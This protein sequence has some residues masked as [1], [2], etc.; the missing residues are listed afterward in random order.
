MFL[1][2][3]F[4]QPQLYEPQSAWLR[5]GPF[6]LWLVQALRPRR[7]VELGTHH[8]Y[9]YFCFCQ[10]VAEA[11]LLTDCYAVDTWLGDEH[12]G[13]YG[14]EIYD[15]VVE[16]NAPY[17]GFSKLLR[18]TFAE[19]LADIEDGS[20]D[21]LHVDGRHFYEDVKEDF[22]SW[23]P[24]LSPRAVVLFHDT[25]VKQKG[26]GV[27]RYW[28]EIAPSRPSINLPYQHGLGVLF[29]GS[30]IA[31]GLK[32]FVA[33]IDDPTGV[34]GI[35]N[36][37]QT[38]GDGFAASQEL[39]A[40]Q[41]KLSAE[42]DGAWNL[43]AQLET[44]RSTHAAELMAAQN[45]NE[46]LRRMVTKFLRSPLVPLRESIQ[47]HCA[48]KLSK[49]LEKAR[50]ATSQKYARSAAKRD[51]KR[52]MT[53]AAPISSMVTAAAAPMVGSDEQ[54]GTPTVLLP[55]A[56]PLIHARP[57]MR[58]AV[59]LHVYYLDQA[60][61]FRDALRAIPVPFSLFVSTDTNAKAEVL[62]K[63]FAKGPAK[64]TEVRV[65]P[66]RGRAIAPKLVGF[67]DI[68]DS[69]ELILFLHTKA[70]LHNSALHGWRDYLIRAL[71]GSRQ[72]VQSIL[73]AFSIA[74]ELGIIAPPN[75]PAVREW[76][77]WTVCYD[78]ARTLARRMGVTLSADSPVAFPAGSMFWAR[79]AAIRPLLDSDIRLEDF[80]E[81][82]G[83]TDGTFAHAVER[84]FF[85]AC[86]VAGL[87]W[88][89][90]GAPDQLAYTDRPL[91][92]EK[93]LDLE[94]ALS[95]QMPAL[96]L[97]GT[98]PHVKS[99]ANPKARLA[100][101][102]EEF[103][104]CCSWDLR[105]FL[106]SDDR[107][108]F[109]MPGDAPKLSIILVLYNQ[110]ELTFHCLQSLQ[111]DAGLPVEIIILDNGSTDYTAALLERLD[112]VTILR[113]TENLH[114]LRGVNRAAHEAHGKHLLLLNNDARVL[115]MAIPT[116]IARLEE[117]EGIGAVGGPIVLLD[118]TLQ[119]AGSIIFNNAACLGYGRGRDP[120][121][122][123]FRFRRDVDYCSGA[124]LMMRRA[125]WEEL[126]GFDES[127]APAYYEET[128]LCMRIWETGRRVV[129]D[130]DVKIVHFEFGSSKTSDAAIELQKRNSDIFRFKHAK[131][132]SSRHL[133]V[134]APPVRARQRR[135]SAPRL[136]VVDDRVPMPNLGSGYP[137]A[138]QML[139]E[140]SAAGWSATLYSTAVPYFSCEKAYKAIPATTELTYG[141]PNVSLANFLRD[142]LGCFDTILISRPHNMVRFRKA[143][144]QVPGWERVPILYDAEA[145]FAERDFALSQ[146]GSGKV[147]DYRQ[148]L[149]DELALAK[150]VRTVFSVSGTEAAT[151]RA[152]GY[153]DVRIL[154]HALS[155][156]PVGDGPEGR[157][158]ML[159]VGALDDDHSP[160]VDSLDWFVRTVMPRIDAA[161]G[162][163]WWLDVAGR[164]GA[165]TL[166]TLESNR[167]RIHGKID[168]LDP[169]YARSRIFIAPT[170]YAA[171]IPMKVHE[172]ASVGLPTVATDLLAR[173]LSWTHGQE[174]MCATGPDD[175]AACCV[176]LHR[177]D[178]LWS[179]LRAGGLA[180][181]RRD[182][183][184][185]AFR[186][187]LRG[188]LRDSL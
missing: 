98:R 67:A 177:D 68:Y 88:L 3:T 86:E 45:E 123:E 161:I 2:Y 138:A 174:L 102:K 148:A 8:G 105:S 65:M 87:R 146:L 153:N 97:P 133:P 49:L 41:L 142:R 125:L 100:A 183:A 76:S 4:T 188:A 40:T 19:A 145:I 103:R 14:D 150:G 29:W 182:C 69:Q 89:H 7:I 23:I 176:K 28:A 20:V 24:K 149:A 99:L 81:E 16:R 131:A 152:H 54:E 66:N 185:E 107:L 15:L 96:L 55:F 180:S 42:R 59:V 72:T 73:D 118:G 140:I 108:V 111:R 187:T 110:A 134:T 46:T 139:S 53:L 169:F 184:P 114:F 126:G 56:S 121:E 137:R 71:L 104:A 6:A 179:L 159:F 80:P 18:K 117:D 116:A 50:P 129:Y 156:R 37:F 77:N 34:A 85:Y 130:P 26:F 9:S 115:P 78:A 64:E 35:I 186:D 109:E 84:L 36:V 63:I 165:R 95:D 181:I 31:D 39:A 58:V 160:N 163:D 47:H 79:P 144:A 91:H 124:F 132:L 135:D 1:D 155:P 128:D 43:R 147:F 17:E 13:F 158:N 92:I 21:L 171:G 143:V 167:V 170:R 70:T 127:F 48:L 11:E 82:A 120:G 52:F 38:I 27:W 119:E 83:Q 94:W 112:G 10:A 106:A 151:F 75:Y 136:L 141:E 22:E 33:R 62:R 44:L 168:D 12:A 90:A 157:Q 164:A 30:E 178:T 74:P 172:A 113:N 57:Q 162:T 175:F 122:A 61:S 93:Q 154:G 166:R 60:K 51:P 173:Q 32:S 25:E 5:H 101:A